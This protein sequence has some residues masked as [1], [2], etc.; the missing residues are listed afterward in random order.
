M[1][2]IPAQWRGVSLEA[3]AIERAIRRSPAVNVNA[4]ALRSRTR[5]LA[6][7]YFKL[8]RPSLE[9]AGL[10]RDS[11]AALDREFQDLLRLATGMN[12][13]A[14]YLRSLGSLHSLA[15][16]VEV[17]LVVRFAVPARAG[18]LVLTPQEASIL[19]TLERLVPTAALSYRQA[20]VDLQQET[21][22]SWRGTAS[23]LRELLRET[24]DHLAPDRDV[25]A[26]KGFAIE[27]GRTGPTM[28]QKVRFILQ[29]REVPSGARAAPQDM[30]VAIEALVGSLA[31][32]I[33]DRGSLD[34]HIAASRQ[35]VRQ[36][37][38]YIDTILSDVLA[39][40]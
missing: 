6:L 10:S 27:K 28:A 38:R 1:P 33:Y 19:Q 24:L 13:K 26:A 14:S 25:V 3:A 5:Q 35:E 11:A 23:E 17:E 30:A 29:S 8:A 2:D 20:M 12:P 16:D 18:E 15:P 9:A 34:T 37:K 32:S 36:L 31:R 21:H 39:L 40:A 22:L 4:T 7:R